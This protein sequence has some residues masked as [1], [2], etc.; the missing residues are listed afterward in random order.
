MGEQKTKTGTKSTSAPPVKT[1]KSKD[2]KNEELEQSTEEVKDAI[3]ELI[4]DKTEEIDLID[5][6]DAVL[7]ENAEEFVKNY[8]QRGGE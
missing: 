7:E 1:Q 5:E 8:V 3:D 6:I 2:L 4:E